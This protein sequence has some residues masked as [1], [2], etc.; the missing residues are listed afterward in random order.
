MKQRR[1]MKDDVRI[2]LDRTKRFLQVRHVRRLPHDDAF[3]VIDLVVLPDCD[4]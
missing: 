1:I 3:T 4:G 2:L